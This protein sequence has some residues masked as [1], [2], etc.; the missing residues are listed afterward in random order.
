MIQCTFYNSHVIMKWVGSFTRIV[1]VQVLQV[2]KE[3]RTVFLC[4]TNLEDAVLQSDSR[5]PLLLV[6]VPYSTFP[7]VPLKQLPI[8]NFFTCHQPFYSSSGFL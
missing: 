3:L 1:N 5:P 8:L 6:Q 2:L 4:S 7:F